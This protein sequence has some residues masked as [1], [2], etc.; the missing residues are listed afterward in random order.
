[1]PQITWYLNGSSVISNSSVVEI[2]EARKTQHEGLY[3]CEA[4]NPAGIVSASA[5]VT[6]KGQHD[7]KMF[8]LNEC[9]MCTT[10]FSDR[11]VFGV[12]L[13]HPSLG[14]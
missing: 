5:F 7:R 4:K 9:S 12:F 8:I 6:V 10:N 11:N 1:M 2:I 14:H 13:A 3:R